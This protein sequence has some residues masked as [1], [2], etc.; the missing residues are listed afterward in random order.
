MSEQPPKPLISGINP[1]NAF[2]ASLLVRILAGLSQERRTRFGRWIGRVVFAFGIR[3]AVTLD[4][5]RQAFPE[6]SEQRNR[7]IARG[8]YESMALGMVEAIASV[9][10]P[11]AELDHLVEVENWGELK[12]YVDARQG[13]L[14]ATGHFGNWELLGEVMC[15]RGVKLSVVVKP[16]KGALNSKIMEARQKAGIRLIL[17]RGSVQ[18]A[19]DSLNEGFTTA[20]LVDQVLPENRGVF[21]PFFGRPACTTPALAIAAQRTGAPIFVVMAAREGERLRMFVDGPIPVPNSGDKDADIR[22]VTATVTALIE[23][24]IRRYPDQWLWLHRRWKVQPTLLK[25]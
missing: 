20:M 6:H 12:K 2:F 13:V 7:E 21:V 3:R 9:G 1:V 23:K 5:L 14:V 8:A 4:N 22:E 16:L 25:G 10:L 11:P 18:G 17:A 19:V 15:R 24:Y